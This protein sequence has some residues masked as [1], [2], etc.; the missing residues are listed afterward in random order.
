VVPW[1]PLAEEH[2]VQVIPRRVR[3]YSFDATNLLP[4]FDRIAVAQR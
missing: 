4:A 3:A 2:Y 1:V